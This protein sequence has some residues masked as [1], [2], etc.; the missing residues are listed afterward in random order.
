VAPGALHAGYLPRRSAVRVARTTTHFGTVLHAPHDG[1]QPTR[2]E[3]ILGRRSTRLSG[4]YDEI[5]G[6][7]PPSP[8]PPLGPDHGR[9]LLELLGL[10]DGA[11]LVVAPL[12]ASTCPR[13]LPHPPGQPETLREG[14]YTAEGKRKER[15]GSQPKY[16]VLSR[17]PGASVRSP[18]WA[19]VQRP[20]A[21]LP[22]SM[23]TAPLCPLSQ[24]RRRALR[25]LRG[26]RS[27]L[28]RPHA[29][30]RPAI[31]AGGLT[32]LGIRY[33]PVRSIRA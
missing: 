1:S 12:P 8:A 4:V 27:R 26:H 11:H 7:S 13:F 28:R 16:R 24:R 22:S 3:A 17:A 32:I 18:R 19:T 31:S 2:L 5:L 9:H 14:P 29:L 25:G 6:V 33:S 15:P 21:G 10:E 23:P 20:F 30:Q